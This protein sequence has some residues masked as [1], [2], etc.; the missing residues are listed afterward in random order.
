[1]KSQ[2]TNAFLLNNYWNNHLW[3]CIVVEAYLTLSYSI[4]IDD[5]NLLKIAMQE[6]AIILQAFSAKKPKYYKKMGYQMH[7]LDIKAAHPIL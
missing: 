5:I 7:I 2:C 1:M 6:I 3:F 4:K